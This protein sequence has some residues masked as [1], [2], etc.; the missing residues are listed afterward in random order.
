M[1]IGLPPTRASRTSLGLCAVSLIGLLASSLFA[2]S[3]SDDSPA[4]AT[5]T[6]GNPLLGPGEVCFTPQASHVRIRVEP[7]SIVVPPCATGPGDPTCVG[8]IVKVIVDP[9]FCVRTPVTFLSQD[10]TIVPADNTSYVELH[11]PTIPVRVVGGTKTG[12]TTVTV[13]VPRGDGTDATATLNVEVAEPKPIACSGGPVSGMV[14]GGGSVRGKDGLAGASISLPKGADA[15]NSNSFLWSVEPFN[16]DVSCGS[17]ATP[18]GYIALG[19][20]ITFGPTD[21]VFNREVPVSIPINPAL[22]PQAAR[23]RHIRLA[24][25]GPAFSKPRTIPV[26]DPRVEKVDG[27]WAVTF[28]APRLG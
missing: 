22:M 16:A 18:D 7:S 21:K 8:R 10:Q 15:P 24:Y 1:R 19:P 3:C 4:T 5:T 28:K 26:A 12:S 17:A 6:G 14:T 13:S 9:D 25:S 20:P 11:L 27:Q 23:Q 2:P